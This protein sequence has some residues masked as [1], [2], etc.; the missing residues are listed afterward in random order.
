MIRR[1]IILLLIVGCEEPSQHGC[2]DSQAT[3]YDATA[4]ID[5]NSCTYI[6][7]CD[8]CDVAWL[9]SDSKI[10]WTS[11]YKPETLIDT[12]LNIPNTIS[13]DM[14]Y[15]HNFSIWWSEVGDSI[16]AN[17]YSQLD[18]I[19]DANAYQNEPFDCQSQVM[20]YNFCNTVYGSDIEGTW[21]S[22][23]SSFFSYIF[24]ND[25]L[26]YAD[27]VMSI[28]HFVIPNYFETIDADSIINTIIYSDN[29]KYE[30][31]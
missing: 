2:L 13:P 1:L 28:S 11:G 18:S 31:K 30:Y 19:T 17:H 24:K 22:N 15:P 29:I 26:Q 7:T 5:N 10:Y 14:C 27:S 6:D 8:I 4:S 3:N 9:I 23:C 12:S 21:N 16:L 25:T 20:D